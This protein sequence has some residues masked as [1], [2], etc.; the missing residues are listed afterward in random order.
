MAH[1]K[2]TVAPAP[3]AVTA[4]AAELK[5]KYPERVPVV[6]TIVRKASS[7][8]PTQTMK[9]LVPRNVSLDAVKVL[10]R[11]RIKP[12]ITT[13]EG[14]FFL[15]G[16]CDGEKVMCMGNATVAALHDAHAG[17]DGF[18]SITCATENT[19][20]SLGADTG[21]IFPSLPL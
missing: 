8:T 4:T 2:A 16:P 11:K 1:G 12:K 21:H 14:M 15:C 6:M 20:G 10:V 7:E 19:F 3:D 5:V 9:F 17:P 13:A 18:L